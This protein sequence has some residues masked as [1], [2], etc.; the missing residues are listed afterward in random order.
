MFRR[1]CRSAPQGGVSDGRLESQGETGHSKK[2]SLLP[3]F[4][5]LRRKEH[6]KRGQ[7]SEAQE[8][9]SDSDSDVLSTGSLADALSA[10]PF[11]DPQLR[12]H[13]ERVLGAA[14]VTSLV[15]QLCSTIRKC[16]GTGMPDAEDEVLRGVSKLQEALVRES[17]DVAKRIL[18]TEAERKYS[19]LKASHL[20]EISRLRESQ[21]S[22]SLEGYVQRCVELSVRDIT[23]KQ[24]RSSEA[25]LQVARLEKQL[26]ILRTQLDLAETK[27]AISHAELGKSEERCKMLERDLAASRE[28]YQC[29]QQSMEHLVVQASAE[30]SGGCHCAEPA[31]EE[32]ALFAAQRAYHSECPPYISYSSE[33]QYASEAQ[34]SVDCPSMLPAPTPRSGSKAK[35]QEVDTLLAEHDAMDRAA[36]ALATD[37]ALPEDSLFRLRRKSD[38]VPGLGGVVP[39]SP[40]DAALQ[41]PMARG[42]GGA[43][44]AATAPAAGIALPAVVNSPVAS[45]SSSKGRRGSG[46]QGAKHSARRAKTHAGQ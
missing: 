14:P 16:V 35:R 1:H 3:S 21:P 2:Q 18:E 28:E 22:N 46:S 20:Q 15:D 32:A 12:D 17:W 10:P 24:R 4:L 44:M 26:R 33:C 37:R 39:A 27:V 36:H 13:N 8:Q 19:E 45:P 9:A 40:P 43:A 5:A 25:E 38:T 34:S 41:L 29:F 6:I 42:G 7:R 11:L 23:D 31:R 30:A